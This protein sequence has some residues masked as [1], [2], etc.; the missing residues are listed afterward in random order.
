MTFKKDNT[1]AVSRSSGG[2]NSQAKADW[3]YA[4]LIRV[5]DARSLFI[6]HHSYKLRRFIVAIAENRM[7][8]IFIL[9]LIVI[10]SFS[11]AF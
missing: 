5:Y 8:D 10:N 4:K 3:E 9:S 11:M 7:F 1:D 6:L 2:T